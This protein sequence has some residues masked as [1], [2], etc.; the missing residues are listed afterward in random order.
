[1]REREFRKAILQADVPLI[2][3][4]DMRATFAAN[5]CM[6]PGG[7]LYALSKI[8]GHSNVDMTVKRYAHLH[9]DFLK[10]VA[11]SVNFS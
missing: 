3:F 1:M 8:L 2:R 9:N 7:D 11:S 4:H 6:A 5:V 10:K